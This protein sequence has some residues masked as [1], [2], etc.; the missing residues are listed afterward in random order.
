[1]APNRR[2]FQ[3][4]AFVSI[5]LS[6]TAHVLGMA[7]TRQLETPSE[8]E[9]G[10]LAAE[11]ALGSSFQDLVKAGNEIAPDDP[12]RLPMTDDNEPLEAKVVL[13]IAHEIEVDPAK[14]IDN[15]QAIE[16][17]QPSETL[18]DQ[19]KLSSAD[20][21]AA[22]KQ[23]AHETQ[24][25]RV[26]TPITADSIPSPIPPAIIE[27]VQ[28]VENIVSV[29]PSSPTS[30]K[31]ASAIAETEVAMIMP[32]KPS[33]IL[34]SLDAQ[35]QFPIPQVRP[36]RPKQKTA[37]P[38]KKT[39]N[40]PPKQVAKKP[41]KGSENSKAKANAK[42]G[43]QSGKL[44]S[45]EAHASKKSKRKSSKAGNAAASNYPGKVHRKIA[46]TSERRAGA[47]GTA[48]VGFTVTANGG[49][50]G[51]SIIRSS[52]NRKVDSVAM[53][54]VKRAAPFP[55]PPSGAQRR[56]VVPIMVRR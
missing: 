51:V 28:N 4:L 25:E 9:G 37:A 42:A 54:Q 27:P 56:F 49:V 40:A 20:S 46:R 5:F 53:S 50:S 6:I 13:A 33:E 34:K 17:T 52:G 36:E 2:T 8:F 7:V 41:A 14:T 26:I 11:T 3:L 21:V 24:V 22:P 35:P 44:K 38:K 48:R 15:V 1:M 45:K 47:K 31:P 29:Q 12:N 39:K 19:A 23:A 55:K 43:S 18:R 32:S 16:P 10:A 30:T